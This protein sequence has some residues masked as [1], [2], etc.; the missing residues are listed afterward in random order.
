MHCTAN[1]YMSCVPYQEL[2]GLLFIPD[3]GS[4]CLAFVQQSLYNPFAYTSCC[5]CMRHKL[6]LL[7]SFAGQPTTSPTA[8]TFNCEFL[9]ESVASCINKNADRLSP[10]TTTTLSL[11]VGAGAPSA[12]SSLSTALCFSCTHTQVKEGYVRR[13]SCQQSMLYAQKVSV[14]RQR[15]LILTSKLA[16]ELSWLFYKSL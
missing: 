15:H 14:K 6:A 13:R 5:P 9:A 8:A 11:E 4:H 12:V 10:A 16:N 7:T 2:P 3:Q 1:T